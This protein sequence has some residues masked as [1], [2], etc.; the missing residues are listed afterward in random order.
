[1]KFLGVVFRAALWRILEVGG[2]GPFWVGGG[3]AQGWFQEYV[4]G[5]RIGSFGIIRRRMER[6]GSLN[7]KNW[8]FWAGLGVSALFLAFLAFSVDFGEL[9]AVLAAADY[10]YVVPAVAFYF[11]GIWF[12]A[13]RWRYVLSPVQRIPARR[14]YP[15]VVVSQA[16]NNL[17]PARLGELLRV[18]FL[19]RRE[20]VSAS[21][22]LAGL[23]VE[24]VYDGLVT[25]ALGLAAL[26]GLY[27]LGELD[28][29]ET[30]HRQVLLFGA[31]GLSGL[32]LTGLG[33]VTWLGVKPGGARFFYPV[34]EELPEAW[35]ERA[36]GL[37]DSFV[38]GLAVV[39]RPG[40]HLSVALRS[41]PI[42]LAEA[43]VYMMVGLSF[44]LPE[45]FGNWLAFAGAVMLV[46][47]VSNLAGAF[48]LSIGGIGPFELAAQVSLVALG[49][50]AETALSYALAVHLL[51]LWLPV[52]LAGLGILGRWGLVIRGKRLSEGCSG[53]I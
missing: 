40:Q 51:A 34:V 49:V 38:A 13:G 26:A 10:R 53:E 37:L 33:L 25:V 14:L 4:N 6:I 15:L 5:Q 17:L 28:S 11:V 31:G 52:N 9:W 41:A 43:L 30:W 20:R 50:P 22:A 12:R 39:K 47:S 8:R 44:G 21:A 36:F 24:R 19:A 45:W 35:R 29:L 7:W 1:M 23:G 2:S 48:P 32:F 27:W 46:T 18:Y 16:G 3:K 42:W